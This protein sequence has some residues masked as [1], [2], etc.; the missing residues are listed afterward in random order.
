ML[1]Y[2]RHTGGELLHPCDYELRIVVEK[3]AIS[4]QEVIKR[5]HDHQLRSAVS[6]IIVELGLRHAETDSPA[7]ASTKQRIS[8]TISLACPGNAWLPHLRDPL[9]KNGYKTSSFHA[10]FTIIP[11]ASKTSLSS[12]GLWLAQYATITRSL[13]RISSGLSHLALCTRG[14]C[15]AIEKPRRT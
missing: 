3:V 4:S 14:V 5:D 10:V 11:S 1:S 6:H 12:S 7:G 2:Q 15:I 9:K 8:R 13:A